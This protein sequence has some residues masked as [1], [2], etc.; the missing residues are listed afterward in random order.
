MLKNK[1]SDQKMKLLDFNTA[2]KP[3]SD[4]KESDGSDKE[5]MNRKHSALNHQGKSKRSKKAWHGT[6]ISIDFRELVG[7]CNKVAAICT[8]KV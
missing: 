7:D 2:A 3:G 8:F 4:Y 6:P 5:D 1:A